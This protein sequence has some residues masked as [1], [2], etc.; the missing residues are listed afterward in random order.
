MRLEKAG[1]PVTLTEED[2]N[3]RSNVYFFQR[4]K[5]DPRQHERQGEPVRT[6][7]QKDRRSRG[8]EGRSQGTGRAHGPPRAHQDRPCPQSSLGEL[9][10]FSRM[11]SSASPADHCM[12]SEGSTGCPRG[13]K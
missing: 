7:G 13:K 6:E 11:P 5:G 10:W 9:E 2:R 4:M 3:E 12:S 1:G 8:S